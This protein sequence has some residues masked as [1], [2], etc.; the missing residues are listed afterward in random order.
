[1]GR[2][3]KSSQPDKQ[4]NSKTCKLAYWKVSF[5]ERFSLFRVSSLEVPLFSSPPPILQVISTTPSTV[6]SSVPSWSSWAFV[7]LLTSSP[8]SGRHRSMRTQSRW[9]TSTPFWPRQPRDSLHSTSTISSHSYHRYFI[10]HLKSLTFNRH[11]GMSS[12]ATIE[13]MWILSFFLWGLHVL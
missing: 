6:T 13:R 11:I 10:T 8:Q 7:S 1:M 9:R 3:G 5:M 12:L 2:I 4:V